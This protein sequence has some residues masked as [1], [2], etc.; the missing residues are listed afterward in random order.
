MDHNKELIQEQYEE[1]NFPTYDLYK[2]EVIKA[3]VPN[4]VPA[5]IDSASDL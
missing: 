2:V 5:I 4:E 3:I 1:Q